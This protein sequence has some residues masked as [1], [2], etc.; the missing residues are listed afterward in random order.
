[1]SGTIQITRTIPRSRQLQFES[2]LG[3][4]TSPLRTGKDV[5]VDSIAFRYHRR[6]PT[7]SAGLSRFRPFSGLKG[8]PWKRKKTEKLK[9]VE[10]ISQ[11][12]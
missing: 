11:T 3:S 1:M 4:H 10:G 7:H 9:Y 8:E 12:G 6:Y 5:F 2:T